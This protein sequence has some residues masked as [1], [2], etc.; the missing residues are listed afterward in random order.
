MAGKGPKLDKK[1]AHKLLDKLSSDDDFRA[2]FEA[3]PHEALAQLGWEP[4]PAAQTGLVAGGGGACLAAGVTLAPKE[5][6]ADDRDALVEALSLPFQFKPP[7]GLL[8]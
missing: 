7:A 4:E 1:T 5:T 6:I 8:K 3:S 2:A